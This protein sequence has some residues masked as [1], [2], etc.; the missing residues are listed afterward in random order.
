MIRLV[1]RNAGSFLYTECEKKTDFSST[2]F[3]V[4]RNKT[5]NLLFLDTNNRNTDNLML[6]LLYIKLFTKNTIITKYAIYSADGRYLSFAISITF[7]TSR[8]T[9]ILEIRSVPNAH[10]CTKR[11]FTHTFIIIYKQNFGI[12]IL[13]RLILP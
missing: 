12:T 1:H 5:S 13:K 11:E 3:H 4:S 8:Q 7:S 2:V 9:S 10:I 6:W